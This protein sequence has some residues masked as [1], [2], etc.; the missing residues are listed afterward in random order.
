MYMDY[1][2]WWQTH[3]EEGLDEIQKDFLNV[4]N[5]V[6]F[7]PAIYNPILYKYYFQDHLKHWDR[8]SMNT[9]YSKIHS[10]C[11]VL[12]NEE[13]KA[14]LL[15]NMNLFIDFLNGIEN[16]SKRI[17]L[18]ENFKGSMELK[19]LLFLINIYNDLLNGPYS[20]ILQIYIKFEG[21]VEGK[22]LDQ[23][24]LTPQM[25]CLSTRNYQ[26]ILN[27]ADANIRN[28]ISH[29]GVKITH[30]QITFSYRKGRETLEEKYSIYEVKDKVITLFDSINGLIISFIGFLI[31]NKVTFDDIYENDELDNDIILFYEKLSMSSQVHSYV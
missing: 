26:E 21:K 7:I 11:K 19:G 28:A 2:Y 8:D 15:E 20:K 23:K 16:I 4:F 30:D 24:T 1:V 9:G 31:E 18:M 17:E 3:K 22:N 10:L 5:K 27:V 29:D 13:F 14:I 12:G 6:D 25:Q